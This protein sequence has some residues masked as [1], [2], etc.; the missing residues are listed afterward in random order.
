MG[1][2]TLASIGIQRRDYEEDDRKKKKTAW[3]LEEYKV[4]ARS[5]ITVSIDPVIDN[6][7]KEEAF[8]KCITEEYNE[9][10]NKDI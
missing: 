1:S 8:W 10:K 7:Q 4:L 5:W 3:S 9:K 6:A 2:I